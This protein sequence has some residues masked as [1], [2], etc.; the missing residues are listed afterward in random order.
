MRA[1]GGELI[2]DHARGEV[3]TFDVELTRRGVEDALLEGFPQRF[4][5]QLGHHD[6]VLRLPADCQ[7]LAFSDK[8]RNQMLRV[9]DLPIYSTQFHPEL[10][11]HHL[12]VRLLMYRDSYLAEQTG[13]SELSLPLRSSVWA[14]R[15]LN[16][17]FDHFVPG[18]R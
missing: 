9:A 16:R 3:G 5:V 15:M 2:T 6:V 13:E 11:E 7:E 17:F 4:A 18:S 1:L 14:D 12:R 10:S 8:C